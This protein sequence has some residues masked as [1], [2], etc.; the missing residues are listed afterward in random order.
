VNILYLAHRIPY[1]PNKGE[2][3]RAFHQ[4]RYLSK[5]HSLHLACLIDEKE[6]IQHI[7]ALEQFCASIDVVYREKATAR[8]LAA[9]A[10]FTNKP[11]SVA[12]FYSRELA[13]KITQ[14]LQ[15]E[16]IDLIFAFSSPMA[17][18]VRHASGVPKV[19]DFVDVD[20]EKWKLYAEYHRFPFSWLYRIEGE[21]LAKYEE[22]IA[23]GFD[24]SLFVSEKEASLF[25]DRVS[26]QPI[27]VIPLGV[28]LDFF[29]PWQDRPPQV[30]PPVIIFIGMMDYFPN[31]D[32]VE[33]FCREIFPLVR[34]TVPQVQFYIVGRAPTQ[35]VLALGRQPQVT[36]TG[37]VPD[38]R[39]YLG[40]A[41]IAV[42]PFRIARGVQSKILEAMAMGVPV[43]GTSLA[44]QGIEATE[45]NGIRKADDPVGFAQE[46]LPFLRDSQYRL[47]CSLQA[48]QYVQQ[49]HRW[50][51]H[52]ACLNSLLREVV[53]ESASRSARWDN[54]RSSIM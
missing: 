5:E 33:Y 11:L 43:V 25:R 50:Q 15:S 31:V 4:I 8:A 40:Q 13:R 49:H 28:D 52:G 26:D 17:E 32:A 16:Q 39:P 3:I 1:P 45:G 7:K 53:E 48:R 20:S 24:R 47:Q 10:L 19:M 44:F 6:D 9:F 27:S 30:V 35:A 29:V 12:S 34:S 42:A 18:Y 37:S 14:R 23:K 54:R 22:E 46:V 36:I 41:A 21:R 38:V 2:K 51:D